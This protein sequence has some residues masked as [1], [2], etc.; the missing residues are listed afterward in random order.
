MSR[1]SGSMSGGDISQYFDLTIKYPKKP[2]VGHHPHGQEHK[3]AISGHEKTIAEAAGVPFGDAIRY[4]VGLGVYLLPRGGDT[5]RRTIR[6]LK[7]YTRE[8]R[9]RT[10]KR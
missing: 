4:D 7:G 6:A 10:V 1:G 8:T 2:G 5:A 9:P 3:L